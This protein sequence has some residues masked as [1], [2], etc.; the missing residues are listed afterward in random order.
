MKSLHAKFLGMTIIVLIAGYGIYMSHQ[1]NKIPSLIEA[2][3]EALA[4]YEF[5]E[6]DCTIYLGCT[7]G[8]MEQCGNLSLVGSFVHTYGCDNGRGTS[9]SPRQEVN[10]YNCDRELTGTEVFNSIG[11]CF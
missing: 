4:D 7:T 10:Y 6:H 9:C 1:N 11:T 5:E 3:I 2:N 8:A